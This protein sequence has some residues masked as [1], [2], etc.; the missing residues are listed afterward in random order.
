[1]TELLNPIAELD[2]PDSGEIITPSEAHPLKKE[3]RFF[4]PDHDCKDPE[5]LLT[6]AKSKLDTYFFKHKPGFG[7]DIQPETL[8]HKLAVKW[9]EDC[10][11][12]EL[13]KSGRIKLQTVQL[14]T[15]KTKLEFRKLERIIPDVKLTS[16][17][18][19]TFAIEIVVTSDISSEKSKLIEE[20]NLPTV[21]VD[22]S[23]FYKKNQHQCR[24]DFDFVKESLEGL[25]TDITLKS[26]AIEPIDLAL[27]TLGLEELKPEPVQ[28][29]NIDNTGCVVVL[30]T[31]GLIVVWNKWIK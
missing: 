16:I 5:R 18:G 27:N 19:L 29:N 24:T 6:P 31:L 11:V 15:S 2:R 1:M 28:S 13:P 4:C 3:R 23:S 21:R 9:F 14:N 22:L 7:H 26:W 12:Y 30:L 17:D 8:L 10:S 20:F 25:L